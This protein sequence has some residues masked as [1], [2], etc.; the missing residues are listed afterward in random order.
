[1]TTHELAEP[2]EV[3]AR[4]AR[5]GGQ[6][7]ASATAFF[8][9]SFLFAYIYLRS[10]DSGGAWRSD[11]VKQPVALGTVFAVLVIAC[12]GAVWLGRADEGR[13][14]ALGVGLALG[15]AAVVVQLLL[16]ATVGFGPHDGG[17]AS[18]FFGWTAFYFL[19]LLLTLVRLEI[20]L[21]TA[22]RNPPGDKASTGAL[23]FYLTFLAGIGVLTWIVLYLVGP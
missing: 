23:S 1:M 15:V 19:F 13:R 11:A 10:L 16:W 9:L 17:Y 4:A 2:P 21:A 6:L 5:V 20:E 14:L 7:L 22:I 18:V 8:F 12:A 3:T